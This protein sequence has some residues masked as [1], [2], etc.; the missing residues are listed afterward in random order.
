MDG[1]VGFI[2]PPPDIRAIV[3]KTAAFVA[4]M[5]DEVEAKLAAAEVA[6]LKFGFL[7]ADDPYHAYYRHKVGEG[8]TGVK[9]D[10]PAPAAPSAA[11]SS[12]PS[13]A[14][15]VPPS[16][17]PPATADAVPA[18]A[19]A[20]ATETRSAA[21]P[22]P[23]A[24][25]LR[26]FDATAP[27]PADEFRVPT[28]AFASAADVE[29]VRVTAQFTAA[30]GRAFLAALT[31]REGGS[32]DFAFLRPS[33][34]L[35]SFFT[36]LVDAYARVL[37][38][39]PALL[40]RLRLVADTPDAL[41]ERCVARMEATR[42]ADEAARAAAGGAG[43]DDAVAA[44]NWHDFTVVETIEF[45]DEA[46][47][48]A[49]A[50]AEESAVAVEAEAEAGVGAGAGAGAV[51]GAGAAAATATAGD[52]SIKIRTDY[53]PAA[54][55]ARAAATQFIHPITGAPLP[56]SEAAG[57]LRVELMD[58]KWRIER[59]RADARAALPSTLAADEDIAANLR[60]LAGKREDIFGGG[61]P[62]VAA[63]PASGVPA[64][65]RAKN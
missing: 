25:A 9:T 3:D 4:R 65:K 18:A 7:R 16:A 31:P 32:A 56:I 61:V 64:G 29:S 15:A 22:N 49:E 55:P 57:T 27:A 51:T 38:P 63:P 24:R 50:A 19:P 20:G 44:I 43:V 35:F 41:L 28:P 5:G 48:A 62:V 52:A 37:R 21:L 53:V 54:A 42:I 60:V 1:I 17:A 34:A 13:T 58:P 39:A 36:A 47:A 23:L 45:D 59:A 6:N 26:A 11:P 30:G 8:R 12:A 33:H 14:A 46:D 10:E 2:R 40:A